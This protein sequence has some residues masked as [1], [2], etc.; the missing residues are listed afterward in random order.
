MSKLIWISAAHWKMHLI[1]SRQVLSGSAVV[2]DSPGPVVVVLVLVVVVVAS[3]VVVV[4]ASRSFSSESKQAVLATTS[5]N[6]ANGTPRAVIADTVPRAATARATAP[7]GRGAL[8]RLRRRGAHGAVIEATLGTGASPAPRVRAQPRG[9][10]A[11]Q[12]QPSRATLSPMRACS[13]RRRSSCTHAPAS[14][15]PAGRARGA[16]GSAVGLAALLVAAPACR[17]KDISFDCENQRMRFNDAAIDEEDDLAAAVPSQGPFPVAMQITSAGINK[18]LV[19]VVDDGVPFSGTVPFGVLPQGPAD[20]SF[21]PTSP[22]EIRFEPIPSCPTC[23]VFHLSFGVKLASPDM[24][25]STGVGFTDLYVPLRLDVDEASG[26]STLVAEYGKAQIGDWYLSVYGFDS[27]THTMLAGALKLLM[28]EEIAANFDDV[29]LLQIGSWDI[30]SGDVKLLVRQ[31]IVQPENDKL[32]LALHTNL[33]LPKGVGLDLSQPLPEGSTMAVSMDPR[34]MLPMAHRMLAE[35]EI[36]RLYDENGNADPHGIYGVTLENVEANEQG[37]ERL[38]TTFRV[39]RVDEG[40]CGYAEAVMPLDLT[41]DNARQ[42]I[43][44]EAGSAAVVAGE[45]S[46]AAAK[47]ETELVDMNQDLI[48]T[49]RKDLAEQ[50]A[51]TFNYASLELENDTLVINNEGI[52]MT[53]TEMRTY[54]NFMVYAKQ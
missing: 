46:G 40:Y 17:G 44:V 16:I 19:N 11:C 18:L 5:V 2:L 3:P 29:E 35:G 31:V 8:Q 26:R 43:L 13:K 51:K 37:L 54:L 53:P 25:L 28:A 47:E 15:Q 24:P 21:E 23:V 6:R 48:D 50:V 34:L 41:V 12:R 10:I 38:D 22:P 4:A 14:A 39:W 9:R 49:F 36:A 7:R 42:H 33:P 20:A 52:D 45:G 1:A 30:G 32:V 27:N